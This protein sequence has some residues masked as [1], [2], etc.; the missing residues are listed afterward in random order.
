MMT[1]APNAKRGY[2]S[3]AN[4]DESSFLK[5]VQTIL[6][7]ESGLCNAQATTQTMDD[8]FTVPLTNTAAGTDAGGATTTTTGPTTTATTPSSTVPAAGSPSTPS[9]PSATP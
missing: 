9:G 5:T 4:Y 3:Q 6:G 8:L 1:T 2:V 7:V